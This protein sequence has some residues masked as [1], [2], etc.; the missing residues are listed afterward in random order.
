MSASNS[1][2]GAALAA[3]TGMS[4]QPISSFQLVFGADWACARGDAGGLDEVVHQL[5]LRVPEALRRMLDNLSQVIK[6][7]SGDPFARWATLRPSLVEYLR[8]DADQEPQQ[9]HC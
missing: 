7:S 9:L 1:G 3:L 8:D 6:L 5:S 4:P 2:V